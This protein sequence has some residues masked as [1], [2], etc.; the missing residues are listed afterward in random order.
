MIG[1]TVRQHLTIKNHAVTQNKLTN[2]DKMT[3]SN[4]NKYVSK[5]YL[6]FFKIVPDEME[7]N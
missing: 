3:S 2:K 1:R 4:I 7:S 6:K 5:C